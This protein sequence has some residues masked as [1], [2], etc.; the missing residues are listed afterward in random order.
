MTAKGWGGGV[1]TG[2]SLFGCV[3]T[4]TTSLDGPSAWQWAAARFRS[5]DQTGSRAL[6]RAAAD[7]HAAGTS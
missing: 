6:V 3:T 2:G 7:R 5:F 4:G 1:V